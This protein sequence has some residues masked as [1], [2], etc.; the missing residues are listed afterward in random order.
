MD[1]GLLVRKE[2]ISTRECN[3]LKRALATD[4]KGRARAGIRHL[5]N[6]VVVRAIAIDDRMVSIASSFL[7]RRAIP[8]RATL[9]EKSDRANW[10]VA[11]HQDTALPL[12]HQFESKEWGPW[13]FKEG[14]TY[15]HAPGW[16][17]SRI[18]ALRIHLDP[19]TELNGP[20]RVIPG[21][22]S[23]GV[24]DDDEVL[25]RAH[26]GNPV[27]CLAPAGAVVAMR[28]LLIHA[29]SKATVNSPRRVLH[30]EYA[31]SLDLADG[32]QLAIT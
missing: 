32:V 15:A 10:L 21:S 31:D 25:R 3:A 14:F 8:Y 29:S 24:L 2:V 22:H 7:G 17:L 26:N 4:S 27:E 18:I 6:N 9:F 19:S 13:S 11:W 5:M 12:R 16:A 20:L 23:S 1:S 30:I 28:P